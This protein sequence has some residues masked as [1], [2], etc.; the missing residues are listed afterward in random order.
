MRL[1]GKH[2]HF[3]GRLDGCYIA[4]YDSNEDSLEMFYSANYNPNGMCLE[5]IRDRIEN[6]LENYRNIRKCL[7]VSLPDGSLIDFVDPVVRRR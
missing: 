4:V 5:Q 3:V 6:C 2:M 1:K 7:G